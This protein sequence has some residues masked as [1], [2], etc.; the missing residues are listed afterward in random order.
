M[1]GELVN[2]FFEFLWAQGFVF[3]SVSFGS[4]CNPVLV[5]LGYFMVFGCGEF[6]DCSCEFCSADLTITVSVGH[7][8]DLFGSCSINTGISDLDFHGGSGS[9]EGNSSEFH[10][11]CLFVLFLLFF[12]PNPFA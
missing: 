4:L 6:R 7:A 10:F 12:I 11:V 8:E 2:P 5:G 9:N 1:S 3:T